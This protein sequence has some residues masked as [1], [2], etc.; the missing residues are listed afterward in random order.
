MTDR[1]ALVLL[2]ALHAAMVAV[3][4]PRGDFPL[5][6]DW[7][8]AQSVSWLLA[9]GRIRLSDWAGMNLVPQTMLASAAV[10]MFGPGFE[11]LRHVTQ[12]VA[13]AAMGA[14]YAWFRASRLDAR[15][16]LVATAALMSFPA[17]DV[18]ANSFMTDIYGLALLLAAAACFARHLSGRAPGM[19]VA[20]T[21]F[22]VAGVLQ[23]Q[24][25]LAIAFA[26]M[27]AV[28]W[29]ERPLRWRGVARAGIPFAL[30]LAAE[31]AFHAYLAAGPGVPG[32]QRMLH[33]R[34]V[35][36]LL[37]IFTGEGGHRAWAISNAVTIAGYLGLFGAGWFAWWG[38]RGA[39]PVARWSVA[40][41]GVLVASV[42]LASDWL[43][44]YRP[45]NVL[46][47]VGIGPIML[48][49]TVRGL[50]PLDRGA[51]IF[52]R[53]LAI[54]A[55]FATVALVVLL[56][57]ASA[58]AVRS[59]RHADPLQVFMV[60]AI[61]AY[62]GP[63]VATDYGDRYLLYALPFVFALWSATW[64]AGPARPWSRGLGL[65]WI[66]LALFLGA[67]ATR[68]Y[69]AWNRAR[70][71]ALRD[72]E[73]SGVTADAIDGG[74][75]Y[76]ALRRFETS[77]RGPWPA[78]SWYWVKDDRYVVALGPV[79]GYREIRSTPVPHWLPRSPARVLLLERQAR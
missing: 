51:G 30:V 55:A 16:A 76:N 31:L 44:P 5:N 37:E 52:W 45:D 66:A 46:D 79:P 9:E 36:L 4:M 7:A 61:V 28:L 34:I 75:E 78:K 24:V 18:L 40:V 54:P 50:A 33:G 67:A 6:D 47:A 19:L 14:A 42:A 64:T 73:S 20:A 77:A 27:I 60:V 49:D 71:D 8:Y 2:A 65:A 38:M 62:L 32:G 12:A 23:R 53:A 29:T 22:A 70:W 72:L 68:D 3:V 25:A 39:G 11:T 13:L 48:H 56:V 57:H 10:G 58:S 74:F 26:Y 17:W 69:F 59:G 43:P 63:F 15:A 1:R 41:G 35:P 21:A